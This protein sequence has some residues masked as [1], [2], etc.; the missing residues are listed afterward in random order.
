MPKSNP[1]GLAALFAIL[2]LGSAHAAVKGVTIAPKPA[3]V[4]R[5]QT[6]QFSATV[7]VTP[8][9]TDQS[10][11]WSVT[12][13]TTG[14]P[15]A[16][17]DPVSGLF[18][19][20]LPTANATYKV[21][22]T[23]VASPA[24]SASANVTVP[25]VKV[26][27]LPAN[28]KPVIKGTTQQFTTTVLNAPNS[29]VIY[30]VVEANGGAIDQNGLYTAP[31]VPGTYHVKATSLEDSTK[32]DQSAVT[33][34]A[35]KV[36]ID[37]T[38]A[39]LFVRDQLPFTATVTGT[40]NTAVS[41]TVTG[42]SLDDATANPVTFR[43]PSSI[44]SASS[45]T[46][47]LKVTTAD[48]AKTAST[49]IT[50]QNHAVI[51]IS[52]TSSLVYAGETQQFTA[53]VTGISNVGVIWT[54]PDGG[55]V[56]SAG[57]F[58]APRTFG[59]YRVIATS[60]GDPSR[61]ANAQVAV[62]LRTVISTGGY[63]S[64]VLKPD[65]TLWEWGGGSGGPRGDGT[66]WVAN[67]SHL[68]SVT[69]AVGLAADGTLWSLAPNTDTPTPVPGG[70]NFV[71]VSTGYGHTVGLKADGTL[72]AW[73]YNGFG[74]LGDGTTTDRTTLTPVLGGNGFIAVAAGGEHTLALKA[75]GTLWAWGH[76]FAG[77]IGDG[78]TT[79]EY[80]PTPVLA[81]NGF[82]AVSAGGMHSL[83]LQSDGTVWAWGYNG[84]GQL[85]DGTTTDRAIPG[86]VQ[87]LPNVLTL[88]AGFYHNLALTADGVWAWGANDD[89]QLG[90]GT[91]GALDP[92][93][94][95]PIQVLSG[96]GFVDIAAGV[97]SSFAIQ[98][99]GRTWAWGANRFGSL[100]LGFAASNGIFPVPTEYRS[101]YSLISASQGGSVH[102]SVV[103]SDGSLW[104]W[105]DNYVGQLGN[106]TTDQQPTAAYVGPGFVQVGAGGVHAAGLGPDGTL[107]AWGGNSNGQIG[108]GTTNAH[109]SPVQIYVGKPIKQVSVGRFYT[110]ALTTDGEAWG[111][112][113]NAYGQLG[114]GTSQNSRPSPLLIGTGFTEVAANDR[115]SLG[116]KSD[117][118]L[119][120]WGSNASGQL[121]DGTTT[122][123]LVPVQVATSVGKPFQHVVAGGSHTLALTTDGELWGWGSGVPVPVLLGT[124][125][126]AFA[127]GDVHSL[128]V[129]SDGTLWAWG[130]N[131]FGQL[132]DGSTTSSGLPKQ[133]GTGFVSVSAGDLYSFAISV[134][135]TAW[136]W[137]FNDHG[138][139]GLG[140]T[141]NQ[142][143][144]VIILGP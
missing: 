111:W 86:L 59:Y 49:K 131:T 72:W 85:G 38:S 87:G 78:T 144:P 121:G 18:Q 3:T 27:L 56:S 33:V 37:P 6:Q 100:G 26:T 17:I 70:T 97:F 141:V 106:G 75:D 48:S 134:D 117:G 35:V 104:G 36:T 20:P 74:Q 50:I 107:W 62:R 12:T 1:G 23:S 83:A 115:H 112:G 53:T 76:N 82:I 113:W 44:G 58:T 125:F 9:T 124:G 2:C 84:L 109:I 92:Y 34:P 31:L 71:A 47:T 116:I 67:G 43:A 136:G 28:A 137:G 15:A 55:S 21:T 32:T 91:Y 110:L 96:G 122:D 57:L 39:A 143:Q 64:V 51:T 79:D 81:G 129:K 8:P 66:R 22:A 73:G 90:E 77:Q 118:S 65:G 135:G 103:K 128:A 4:L 24:K 132:G 120:A 98:A 41:W 89:G 29:G 126:T 133:V 45:V 52:P 25:A 40:L 60:A 123:Q 140:N 30:S 42:G 11:T 5:G 68:V 19:A 101:G 80:V 69:T 142:L 105:G 7:T 139:L 54:A 119:W 16:S 138:E 13:V 108:D 63:Y 46:Y 10:V 88:A 102:T 95:S 127:A 93:R 114:D 99:D 14:A 61:W 130:S 94:T